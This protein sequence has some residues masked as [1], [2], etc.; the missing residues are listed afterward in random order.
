MGN[1]GIDRERKVDV[2]PRALRHLLSNSASVQIVLFV[3]AT[4]LAYALS[5]Q[6][7]SS[8]EYI[9]M[10]EIVK[11]YLIMKCISKDH[12]ASPPARRL[13]PPQ[14]SMLLSI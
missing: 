14:W 12:L 2:K 10:S 9:C 4:V 6:A 13:S 5:L 1:T 7:V 3:T 11:H 8:E